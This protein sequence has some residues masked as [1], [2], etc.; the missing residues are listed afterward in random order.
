MHRSI[1][2]GSGRLALAFGLALG[3]AACEIPPAPAVDPAP[4]VLTSTGGYVRSDAPP[5]IE[6]FLNSKQVRPAGGS[7]ARRRARTGDR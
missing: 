1:M 2:G 6:V 3:I 5:G 7:T 4:F